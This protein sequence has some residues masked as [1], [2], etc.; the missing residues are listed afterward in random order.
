[1][2]EV[3]N[4]IAAVLM[5]LG[6][7]FCLSAAVGIVRFPDVITRL[8]AATKPQVFG[9]LLILTAVVLS[10]RTWQSLGIC[11]LVALF[12]IVT[13]PV[14]AHMVSRTAYR[15]G[16]WDPGAAVVDELGDDLAK[17][18]FT[19]QDESAG[20]ARLRQGLEQDERE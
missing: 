6:A 15:T 20:A 2:A 10:L 16:L 1:M 3:A 18:G 14:S 9:L 8:H 5:L 11:A 13:A 17:A 7:V 4:L 12:Q 19:H